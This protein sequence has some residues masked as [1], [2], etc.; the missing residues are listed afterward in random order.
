MQLRP[1]QQK[2]IDALFAYFD[3]N[4]TG[5]PCLVLPTGAG[6][7]HVVAAFCKTVVQTWPDQK[8]L[9]LTHVKEL[10]EQNA[11]KMRQHWPNAPLGIYSAGLKQKN[12][13]SITFGGIQS[14]RTKAAALGHV[15][16]ILIDECHLVGHNAE[17][18]YRELIA[19]LTLINPA[20]RVIG[21]TATPF[22]LGHGYIHEGKGVIFTH[23][24]EPVLIEDLIYEGYLAPLRSKITATKLLTDGVHKRGG[25]YIESELQAAVD[26]PALNTKVV[27]EIVKYGHDRKSWLVFCA[28]VEHAEHVC[29]ELTD[30]HG[31][32]AACV[33][34]KTPANER[35]SILQRFKAGDLQAV[36]NVSVLTTGFDA[37]NTDLIA[38]LR[39]TESPAL[40]MQMAGRGL[41]LKDHCTDCL[42]LDFAG[43][44]SRHGPV[45]SITPP[46]QK[47]NAPKTCP[48][49][50][51]IVPPACRVCECCGFEFPPP[52]PKEPQGRGDP[53]GK[54]QLCQDNIMAYENQFLDVSSV[55]WSVHKSKTT[56]L[57]MLKA[58][59]YGGLTDP[60]IDAYYG[61]YGYDDRPFY[62]NK[63]R[64]TVSR[65][66]VNDWDW[67]SDQS[68]ESLE[69]ICFDLSYIG[70]KPAA[71]EYK[72]NGKF[73]NILNIIWS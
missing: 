14:L 32:N 33:T 40:Y 48:D 12:I 21:L 54:L 30:Q 37:P 19:D 67:V 65:F 50:D 9:M 36:V 61:V 5:N 55:T 31:I 47:H 53:S 6:K 38:M 20:L 46:D 49:C 15:D 11:E 70:R 7:S 60:S 58:R 39:P 69:N 44:V 45:T 57:K 28:G 35:A 1:Y 27:S 23:L 4:K 8:I 24:I 16:L 42:V 18:G 73:Y 52:E 71:I 72:R 41:R 2:A 29:T 10:I 43:N 3:H 22:R 63:C 62:R 64:Q 13:S 56:G 17:G 66:L 26:T 25:D 51:E 68:S 34:G 59:F